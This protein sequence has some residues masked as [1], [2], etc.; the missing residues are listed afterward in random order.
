MVVIKMGREDSCA[1]KETTTGSATIPPDFVPYVVELVIMRSPEEPLRHYVYVY[2]NGGNLVIELH[3]ENPP[4]LTNQIGF[5]GQHWIITKARANE[6]F[7]DYVVTKQGGCQIRHLVE[8]CRLKMLYHG[9]QGFNVTTRH[10]L[11]DGR[12]QHE[13][14]PA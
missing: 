14:S 8:S 4:T 6:A 13:N 9:G 1:M 5:Y 10:F 7:T 12:Y 11:S 3:Q 2:S